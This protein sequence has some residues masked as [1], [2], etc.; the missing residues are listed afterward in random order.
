MATKPQ[1]LHKLIKIRATLVKFKLSVKSV[2]PV[3]EN[4]LKRDKPPL[5][6][7]LLREI[8]SMLQDRQYLKSSRLQTTEID[9]EICQLLEV[10]ERMS[11]FLKREDNKS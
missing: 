11:P 2:D 1:Q 8:E 3:L 9:R 4:L 5:D 7:K 10:S 6:A